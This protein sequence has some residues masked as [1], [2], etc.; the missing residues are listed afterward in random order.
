MPDPSPASPTPEPSLF[1][2][3]FAATRTF[4]DVPLVYRQCDAILE[5]YGGVHLIHGH[6]RSRDGVL[7]SDMIADAWAVQRAGEGRPVTVERFPA[8]WDLLGKAAGPARYGFMVGLLIGRGS[9]PVG[10]IAHIVDGSR[11]ASG[12]AAFAE[13]AGIPTRRYERTTNA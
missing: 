3:L 1:H 10:C 5:R 13:K 8:P 6:Y 4:D 9:R 12:T 7:V 11:G 2:L